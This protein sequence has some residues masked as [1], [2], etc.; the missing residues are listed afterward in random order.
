MLLLINASGFARCNA[1]IVCWTEVLSFGLTFDAIVHS[2]SPRPVTPYSS[3]P[4]TIPCVRLLPAEGAEGISSPLP[5]RLPDCVGAILPLDAFPPDVLPTDALPIDQL[6]SIFSMPS[7]LNTGGS[8]S[9]MY[10]LK[11]RPLGHNTSTIKF[12]KGSMMGFLLV[13]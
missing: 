6:G 10:S 1:S 7:L 5:E 2:V 4:V 13:I 11:I 12:R 9:T 3:S 8:S